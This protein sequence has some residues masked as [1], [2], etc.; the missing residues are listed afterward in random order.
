[1]FDII[2]NNSSYYLDIKNVSK[3]LENKFQKSKYDN[4]TNYEIAEKNQRNIFKILYN[5]GD[6]RHEKCIKFL[7]ESDIVITNPPFSLFREYFDYLIKYNKQ[8]LIIGNLLSAKYKNIF[9][10]IKEFK[11]TLGYNRVENFL[12][13]K[14][15]KCVNCIWITNL[16]VKKISHYNFFTNKYYNNYS[17]FFNINYINNKYPKY[18]NFDA[19]EVIS[20]K[21]IPYDYECLMGLSIAAMYHFDK[22]KFIILSKEDKILLKNKKLF[23]RIIVKKI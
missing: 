4:L 13:E 16:Q 22:T 7:K 15:N 2:D 5:N 19:I 6:F 21:K 8:F 1:M 11:V 23:T 17:D 10:Y 18:D 12:T 9:S 20:Y 3:D 14:V